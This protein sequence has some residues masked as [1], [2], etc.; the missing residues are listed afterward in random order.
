MGN[1]RGERVSGKEREGERGKGKGKMMTI[2]HAAK[3]RSVWCL[4]CGRES[5]AIAPNR[6]LNSCGV[7]RD[8]AD[9]MFE[10]ASLT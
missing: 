7:A 2:K 4:H 5:M 8:L 3:R 1:S 10:P 6:D 9:L